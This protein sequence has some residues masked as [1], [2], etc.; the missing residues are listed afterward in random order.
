MIEI[1]IRKFTV[2]AFERKQKCFTSLLLLCVNV[3]YK[4]I[5]KL[6]EVK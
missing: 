1:I 2:F 6:N 4:Y 3:N 5:K